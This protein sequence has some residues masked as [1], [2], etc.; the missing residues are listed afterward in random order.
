VEINKIKL[1]F[2]Y[3]YLYDN[4]NWP[5]G[6][7]KLAEFFKGTRGYTGGMKDSKTF[8]F[9]FVPKT[10]FLKILRATPQAHQLD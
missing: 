3:I 4:Y 8:E 9:L 6:G 7:T 2:I 1:S 10:D 5:N